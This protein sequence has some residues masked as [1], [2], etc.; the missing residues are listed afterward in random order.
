M[1]LHLNQGHS[2]T[3]DMHVL[4]QS[5][6]KTVLP[7]AACLLYWCL[8]SFSE[9]TRRIYS[10]DEWRELRCWW[11]KW[12]FCLIALKCLSSSNP[13]SVFWREHAFLLTNTVELIWKNISMNQ[14]IFWVLKSYKN[15]IFV[16][17]RFVEIH[18]DATK[19]LMSSKAH[20]E[21][22]TVCRDASADQWPE[23]AVYSTHWL[24]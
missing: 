22:I 12:S 7:K 4:F 20:G 15:L 18:Q 16:K 14:P 23:S 13:E 1:T 2:R 3:R 11:P 21:T 19:S 9:N 5:P 6:C 8:G 10:A 24:C 17:N